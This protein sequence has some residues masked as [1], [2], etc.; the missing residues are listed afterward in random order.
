MA[1]VASIDAWNYCV[2]I[3]SVE[4]ATMKNKYLGMLIYACTIDDNSQIMPLAFAVL[5]SENKLV[6]GMVFFLI[7]KLFLENKMK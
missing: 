1:L 2:P 3:I 7:L 4:G 5:D 6:I